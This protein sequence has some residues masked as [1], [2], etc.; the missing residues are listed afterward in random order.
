M[1]VLHVGKYYPPHMG[2]IESH[3][4]V[5]CEALS[6]EIAIEVLVAADGARGEEEIVAG[7]PVSRLGTSATV[8]S[9]PL[10]PALVGRLRNNDADI[11]HVHVPNPWA[12]LAYL[13]SGIRTPLVVSYH[14]DNVR[15]R[16]LRRVFEPFLHR[17]LRRSSAIIC[18]SRKYVETSSVLQEYQERCCVVPLGV[19]LNDFAHCNR[20]RVAEIRR[21]YDRPIVLTVG[22]QVYYKGFNHLIAAMEHI[23]AQLVL[24]GDGPLRGE[25][26][27]L[28]KRR[29]VADRVHFAGI[30]PN[31]DFVPYYHAADVFV[32]PSVARSEAF[33][34]VQVE[35]MAAGK[36]VI[37]TWLESG[38]PFVS[39]HGTTGLTVPPG[40][41][42]A[43]ASAINRLI[44]DPQLRHEL[45]SA[46]RVRARELFSVDAMARQTLQIYRA[47]KKLQPSIDEPVCVAM[48]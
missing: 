3:L 24:V 31:E 33:G 14:S 47:L 16:L 23:N 25:L 28:A 42:G 44:K 38:V 19:P 22:R 17:F 37:N 48:D 6:K 35:A 11:L 7:I 18:T 34:L 32:L 41:A 27:R 39:V 12:V 43:L 1:K 13:M 45:G 30:V 15:Q 36:P 26:I 9:A 5:L 46:G 20:Q 8:G 40:D 29:G 21:R 2:G 10:C 4:R